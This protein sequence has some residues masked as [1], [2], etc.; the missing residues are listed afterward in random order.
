MDPIS[1]GDHNVSDTRESNEFL[2]KYHV[3]S[4][5]LKKRFLR[6]PNVAEAAEQFAVLAIQC[7]QEELW[8][9]A[10]LSWLAVARCY[11]TLGNTS[12]E[13][14]ELMKAGRQFL[15]AEEKN[16]RIGCPS[17]GQENLQAAVSCFGHSVASVQSDH[18]FG[19]ISAGTVIEL[20][21]AIGP[22][23]AGAQQLRKSISILPT[24]LAIGK[25][26]T[27]YTKQADYGAALSV[28][29]ELVDLIEANVACTKTGNYRKILHKYEVDRVLL[30]LILQ[31]TPQRLPASL[32]EVL[33]K[34][35]W[36]E[37]S[38]S[39]G[40]NMC[41]DEFLLLQS[42]VLA[43]QSHDIQALLELEGELWPYLDTEQKDL[44]RKLVQTLTT[45]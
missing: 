21:S 20:A 15:T 33:E 43:C 23:P 6:K 30:L 37:E 3:I 18:G 12:A 10:G 22:T 35:A 25:L 14:N 1:L 2:A 19:M 16:N 39:V 17:V 7:E 31:P 40:A 36:V 32:G 9:Y 26:A 8:Q 44:L 5:K 29:T 24:T 34:Y 41:E 27:F 11:R 45:Q 38:S 4:N 13:I 42:L 28:I